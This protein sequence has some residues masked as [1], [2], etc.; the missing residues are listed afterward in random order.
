MAEHRLGPQTVG[1]QSLG[2]VHSHAPVSWGPRGAAD[3]RRFQGNNVIY[4]SH[5]SDRPLLPVAWSTAN[6]GAG[7]LLRSQRKDGWRG[8]DEVGAWGEGGSGGEGMGL[9]GI[10]KAELA[11]QVG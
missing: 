6:L 10:W 2:F 8:W 4:Q 11:G 1:P 3:R 9:R 5:S 7:R